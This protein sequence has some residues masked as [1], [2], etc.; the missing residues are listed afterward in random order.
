MTKKLSNLINLI[1]LIEAYEKASYQQK[2]ADLRA[3]AAARKAELALEALQGACPHNDIEETSSYVE[4]GYD[5]C[6]ETFY[7]HTC[8]TCGKVIKSW[9]KSHPGRYG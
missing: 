4:G 5:Y 3:E 8:K 9:S 6:A 7:K 1:N 2:I